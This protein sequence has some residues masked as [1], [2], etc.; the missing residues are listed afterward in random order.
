MVSIRE[1]KVAIRAV[2]FMIISLLNGQ[3]ELIINFGS[4]SPPQLMGQNA[5]GK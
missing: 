5:N 1:D 4:W 3:K 2:N